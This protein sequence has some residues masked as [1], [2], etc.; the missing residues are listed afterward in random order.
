GLIPSPP[1]RLMARYCRD[2]PSSMKRALHGPS[3]HPKATNAQAIAWSRKDGS[4]RKEVGAGHPGQ[5][6]LPILLAP[7]R[8]HLAGKGDR[9]GFPVLGGRP[10]RHLI[11]H[12]LANLDQFHAGMRLAGQN[13]KDWLPCPW[14][15]DGKEE[16]A[17]LGLVGGGLDL[18]QNEKREQ[19]G[20]NRQDH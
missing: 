10:G 15:Q 14:R 4:A 16:A 13:S 20:R 12:L 6:E 2:R 9:D 7:I 19:K 1:I 17:L 3:G 11:R 18:S 5:E 8:E